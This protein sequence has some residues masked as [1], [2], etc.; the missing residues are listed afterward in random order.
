MPESYQYVHLMFNQGRSD[1]NAML[2]CK[3]CP[4][5]TLH[6]ELILS[7]RSMEDFVD[8]NQDVIDQFSR[9]HFLSIMKYKT[10]IY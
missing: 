8:E 3:R 1:P 9:D 6:L 7:N 5:V 4:I 10:K 2:T